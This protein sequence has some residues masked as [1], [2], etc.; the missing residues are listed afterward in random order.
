MGETGSG[1][2]TLANIITGLLPTNMGGRVE[3]DS[4][5]ISTNNRGWFQK[6][7]YVPQYVFLNNSSIK[8]NIISVYIT[9]VAII[10]EH[11]QLWGSFTN[12][13]SNIYLPN[14]KIFTFT[15]SEKT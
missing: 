3:V 5:N 1:K 12:R 11:L 14:K 8:D 15:Q 10:I 13:I 9:N 2:S 7:G 6:I 4:L